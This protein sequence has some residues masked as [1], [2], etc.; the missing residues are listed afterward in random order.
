MLRGLG[1]GQGVV[2]AADHLIQG[3]VGVQH[4]EG[5]GLHG[6]LGLG[7]DIGVVPGAVLIE[8]ILAGDEVV[9]HFVVAQGV[10][11]GIE[12][13][14]VL[15]ILEG[16]DGG[17][18]ALVIPGLLAIVH[19]L[20]VLAAHGLDDQGL[21]ILGQAPQLLAGHAEGDL[22]GGD[23]LVAALHHLFEGGGDVV[24][25]NLGQDVHVGVQGDQGHGVGH[26]VHLA[27]I[28]HVGGHGLGQLGLIGGIGVVQADH[29]A[30]VHELAQEAHAPGEE[31]VGQVFAGGHGGLDLGLVGLVLGGVVLDLDVG[32][33]GLEGGDGV[34]VGLMAG[35]ALGGDGPQ[36]Q[37]DLLL[38]ESGD[39]AEQHQGGQ[40]DG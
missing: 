24:V 7:A 17:D 25:A 21:D 3:D 5:A 16:G 4:R 32:M 38:R 9:L 1:H 11:A 34:D 29:A 26:A 19:G 30:S 39:Q 13:A 2:G 33:V 28:G 20:Q 37:G 12:V 18:D 23:Q 40:Q 15:H 36:L 35:V 10:G 22:A 14:L 27:V 31:Q 8:G 6:E